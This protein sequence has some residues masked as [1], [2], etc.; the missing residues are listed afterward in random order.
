MNY[1]TKIVHDEEI[2]R[3]FARN[4]CPKCQGTLKI[5]GKKN[6]ELVEC[7]HYK[8]Y[9]K[10]HGKSKSCKRWFFE[11]KK[12]KYHCSDSCRN[13]YNQRQKR[14]K[15]HKQMKEDSRKR[16]CQYCHLTILPDDFNITD[17][18]K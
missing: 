4:V 3:R 6:K 5:M 2:D 17:R 9:S 18:F 8:E 10:T 11:T 7:L 12:L 15:N 1:W 16:H 14:K 13:I